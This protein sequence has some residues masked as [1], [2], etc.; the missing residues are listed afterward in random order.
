MIRKRGE[1]R[2]PEHHGD[3]RHRGRGPSSAW[4]HDPK[5]VLGHLPLKPGDVFV[6]LGCGVGEYTL[7]AAAAVG[8]G[9]RVYALDKS[10][11]LI[12]NLSQTIDSQ[13]LS[14]VTPLTTDITASLALD[15]GSVDAV[16]IATVLHIFDLK[17]VGPSIFSEVARI[18]RPGGCLAIVECKKEHQPFGPPMHMRNSPDEIEAALVPYGFEKAGYVDLG[19]NY[20]IH[21]TRG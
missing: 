1:D 12:D 16:F 7:E 5:M 4:L 17:R 18:L 2:R 10:S 21:F 19:Y 20:L 13:A 9:G 8:P 11:H 14:N 3:R 15:D 6:D